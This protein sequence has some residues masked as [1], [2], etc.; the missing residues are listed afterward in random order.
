MRRRLVATALVGVVSLAAGACGGGGSSAIEIVRASSAKTV[1][2]ESSKVSI[3]LKTDVEGETVTFTADGTFDFDERKGVLTLDLGSLLAGTTLETRFLGDTAYVST[4][5]GLTGL[6]GGKKFLKLDIKA[7]AAENKQF[8]SLSGGTD[9]TSG[10]EALRGAKDVTKVGTEDV[11]GESTTHYRGT[12]D[13]AAAKDA[14]EGEAA[15]SVDELVALLK[16]E[17]IPYDVWIDSAG[18]VR[19]TKFV[20]DAPASAKTANQATKTAMT[21]ELYDFGVTVDVTEPPAAEVADGNSL[22]A[23]IGKG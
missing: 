15:E 13:L 21:I 19:R 5:A 9:P 1:A 4:P 10:I 23:G 8:G 14:V 6:L 12:I 7:L 20:V 16:S 3:V 2:A 17:E 22:L 18:R 11:R